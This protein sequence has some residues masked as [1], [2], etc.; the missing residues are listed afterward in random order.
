MT[1]QQPIDLRPKWLIVAQAEGAQ[2]GTVEVDGKQ[3]PY[4]IVKTG[5]A[6]GLP[7]AVGYPT[8]T[9]LMVS[10]DVPEE[11]RAP[12]MSHEVREKTRSLNYRKKSDVKRLYK[13]N[14]TT[15][16]QELQIDM[17]FM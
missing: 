15:C 17:T 10:E 12:I 8:E 7:Y 13:Q 5:L 14:L 9:A 16:D 2:P 6:P 3:Y 4:T 11:D 1:E